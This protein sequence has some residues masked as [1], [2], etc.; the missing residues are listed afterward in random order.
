M[1]ANRHKIPYDWP[2]NDAHQDGLDPT[3]LAPYPN[4]PAK[5]PGVTLEQ[6]QPPSPPLLPQSSTGHDWSR[7]ADEAIVN[8]DLD[9]EE[10]LPSP[11]EVIKMGGNPEYPRLDP[12]NF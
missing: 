2:A 11:L 3:P 4:I 5:I 1:F 12:P 8:A 9:F 7:L 10:H 6:H